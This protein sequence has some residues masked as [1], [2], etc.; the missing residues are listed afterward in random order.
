MHSLEVAARDP[1]AGTELRALL[2]GLVA[3]CGMLARGE[4]GLKH[5]PPD[6]RRLLRRLGVV[7]GAV[8]IFVPA[9][10]KPVPRRLL[11]TIG[12]DPRPLRADMA[13]VIPT[14]RGPLPAGYR[15]AGKQAVR[16]D[17]AEK[18]IRSAH[19]QRTR[20]A[21]RRFGLDEALATSMGLTFASATRLLQQAGFRIAPSAPLA[22]GAH[23][24]PPPRHWSWRAP[25]R[26]T[27]PRKP[28]HAEHPPHAGAPFAELAR[29]I[30]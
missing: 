19:D 12:A 26:L 6:K 29:L 21:G 15:P 14:P 7:I 20:A 16:I 4:A 28:D 17:L 13:P 9:L 23:G 2:L 8:D 22:P 24:P 11:K 18:L 10:L 27:P 25:R 1:A 3:G 5:V 30:R